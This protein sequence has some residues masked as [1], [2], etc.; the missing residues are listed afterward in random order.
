MERKDKK[1]Y[2]ADE[3]LQFFWDYAWENDDLIL[4]ALVQEV[5]RNI[6][7]DEFN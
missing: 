1:V 5:G 6:G 3:V 2:T 4:K 7:S